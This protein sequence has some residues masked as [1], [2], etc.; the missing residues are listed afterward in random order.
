M[1]IG[2]GVGW[3]VV[4]S[5]CAPPLFTIAPYTYIP[6]LGVCAPDFSFG[7]SSLW[8][9]A[10]YTA[11]TLLLPAT[12]IICC[13]LKVCGTKHVVCCRLTSNCVV[14]MANKVHFDGVAYGAVSDD[15]SFIMQLYVHKCL[16]VVAVPV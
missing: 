5:L 2:L 16:L 14:I 13:N 10:V 7:P 9:S 12:L 15:C 11:F 3:V 1:L 4:L 8:Y 6:G